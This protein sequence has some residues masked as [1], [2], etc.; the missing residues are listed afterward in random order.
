MLFNSCSED[1]SEQF[2]H[3][4]A[5]PLEIASV[6]TSDLSTRSSID[7][8]AFPES[9]AASIGLFV[10][11][12]GGAAYN[13]QGAGYSN[14]AYTKAADATAWSCAS[15]ILLS[16]TQGKLYGYYPYSADA[17]DA[18]AIPVVSSVDGDD[19]MYL[20]SPTASINVQT[21]MP[22]NIT[23]QH[24]LSRL[25]ITF[26][27]S[28]T[29]SSASLSSFTLTGDG[30][31]TS[32]TMN[33][34]EGGEITATKASTG[35]TYSPANAVAL[36]A[37]NTYKCL[38]VPATQEAKDLTI[39]CDIND[40]TFCKTLTSVSLKPATRTAVTLTLTGTGVEVSNVSVTG[41]TTNEAPGVE[42][43]AI[44]AT[45]A[46]FIDEDGN[47]VE[48]YTFQWQENDQIGIFPLDKAQM[49]FDVKEANGSTATLDGGSWGVLRPEYS[50]ASY[51]PFSED[52]YHSK[53]SELPVA[54]V[55]QEMDGNDPFA[56][57]GKYDYLVSAPAKTNDQGAFNLDLKHLGCF[58]RFI[59]TIPEP[60]DY[61]SFTL[62]CD[63]VPFIA[64]ATYDLSSATP[65][66]TPTY[67]YSTFKVGLNNIVTTTANEEV[68]IYAMIPPV[69]Q[70]G[71]TL[72]LTL[73]NSAGKSYTTTV[74]GKANMVA[75]KAYKYQPAE[76]FAE[77][78]EFTKAKLVVGTDFNQAIKTLAKGSVVYYSGDDNLIQEIRFDANSS[79]N[80]GKVVS[81]SD[82]P[83]KIYANYAD[84]VI[85]ISTEAD[86]ISGR[87]YG[88]LFNKCK[89]LTSIDFSGFST[90]DATFMKN[91]FSSCSSLTSLDLSGFNTQKVTNMSN[92]FYLCIDLASLDVSSFNTENV[93][94]MSS[95]FSAMSALTSLDLSGFNTQKVTTMASMFNASSK[96]ADLDLSGFDTQNVTNMSGM[97]NNTGFKELDLSGFNTD[98]VTTMSAMFNSCLRLE[99]VNLSSFNT[100]KVTNMSSMFYDCRVLKELD[101]SVLNTENVTTMQ[102]MFSRCDRLETINLS[103]FNTQNVTDMS[104]M[105][106]HCTALKE[107]DLAGLNT[108]NVKSMNAMFESCGSL[109]KL[110]LSSFNT[111]KVTTMERMF[112]FC[113]SLMNLNLSS[114][115]TSNVIKMANMFGWC[116]SMSVLILSEIF[117]IC[118]N[119]NSM[120]SA[121]GYNG[122][123]GRTIDTIRCTAV[124]QQQLQQSSVS[125]TAW[126]KNWDI[127]E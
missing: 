41:W 36:S 68:I 51:Y 5:T 31:A 123:S 110:D 119:N 48:Y 96:L 50:Y 61:R 78:K 38:L 88:H 46:P 21:P 116:E 79:V 84:G 89:K 69:N 47:S 85:T 6:S 72:E 92:M 93:T 124:T 13:G 73:T 115:D 66:L 37:S 20:S 59:L 70:E 90:E 126:V 44:T 111:E 4:D 86:K 98:N 45:V 74:P 57:V 60:G 71:E 114:F 108:E 39:S 19:Y 55:G 64:Q 54:Y 104:S 100:Q 8:T 49:A 42:A 12:E 91:M 18:T 99:S 33:I 40:V 17:T 25:D 106:Y 81:A 27:K 9:D 77:K 82:S 122:P 34:L 101:L 107:L 102:S 22:V 30:V 103:G 113:T 97:F 120:C 67:C 28:E 80:T 63:H 83:Y 95:M 75:G 2:N 15:P 35:F 10:T 7:A 26:V 87:D 16:S 109:K 43:Q 52:N 1:L 14:V 56:H 3:Q 29:V 11:R 32:G 65:V 121:M 62:N 23:M 118:S 127:I 94:D 117:P 105:F 24:A 76:P 58:A 125:L 112:Y 53:I